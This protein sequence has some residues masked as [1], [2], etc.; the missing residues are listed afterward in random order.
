MKKLISELCSHICAL[1]EAEEGLIRYKATLRDELSTLQ[2]Q[3]GIKTKNLKEVHR[4]LDN[5]VKFNDQMV[6]ENSKLKD[7]LIIKDNI[8]KR[9]ENTT[10]AKGEQVMDTEDKMIHMYHQIYGEV[11]SNFSFV[12]T[13]GGYDTDEE[14]ILELLQNGGPYWQA[15]RSE[16]LFDYITKDWEINDKGNL[17]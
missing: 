2:K 13:E 6:A 10:A 14:P 3:H 16:L 12:Y 5:A 9:L 8:I 17:I 15:T 7:L 4:R 11:S 1:Q